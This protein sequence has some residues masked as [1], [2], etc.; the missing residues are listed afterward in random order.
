MN[1]FRM[2]ANLA[3]VGA[4]AALSL[5]ACSPSPGVLPSIVSDGGPNCEGVSFTLSETEAALGHSVDDLLL[6]RTWTIPQAEAVVAPWT[7]DTRPTGAG[8]T[9][10]KVQVTP[11]ANSVRLGQTSPVGP[12]ASSAPCKPSVSIGGVASVEVPELG[13]FFEGELQLYNQYDDVAQLTATVWDPDHAGA[14][15]YDGP[16]T[17][18]GEPTE[19]YGA[20]SPDR[21]LVTL[22]HGDVTGRFRVPDP[23]APNAAPVVVSYLFASW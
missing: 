12:P 22:E 7:G 17:A 6:P 9:I 4:L 2:P 8:T 11:D 10:V 15:P 21:S 16:A 13:I 14:T 19:L 20:F 3:G 18:E 1:N 5:C 23:D